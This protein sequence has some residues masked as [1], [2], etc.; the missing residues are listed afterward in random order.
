M[1]QIN[2]FRTGRVEIV[3]AGVLCLASPVIIFDSAICFAGSISSPLS[4][5]T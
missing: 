4:F 5:I 1:K 2:S 3:L